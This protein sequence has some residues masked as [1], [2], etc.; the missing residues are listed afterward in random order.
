MSKPWLAGAALIAVLVLPAAGHAHD[1]HRHTIM[2]TVTM[3]R[4]TRLEVETAEGKTVA[5]LLNEKTAVLRGKTRL[6]LA[7]V[8]E[9][10]RVVVDVGDGKPPL[11][12]KEIKLGETPARPKK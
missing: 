9:G 11:R 10:Q 6:D 8:K 4:D 1:G 7:A 12:A 3:H 5:I 2:G